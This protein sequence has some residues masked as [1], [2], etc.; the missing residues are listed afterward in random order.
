MT[1]LTTIAGTLIILSACQTSHRSSV[2]EVDEEKLIPNDNPCK[3][4][5][6]QYTMGMANMGLPITREDLSL[7][8][9]LGIAKV[10]LEGWDRMKMDICESTDGV[11]RVERIFK[12]VPSAGGW[13]TTGIILKPSSNDVQAGVEKAVFAQDLSEL[14]ATFYNETDPKKSYLFKGNITKN[15]REK[16]QNGVPPNEEPKTYCEQFLSLSPYDA[17]VP[18]PQPTTVSPRMDGT[19][20][21]P[22]TVYV[23]QLIEFDPF[24]PQWKERRKLIEGSGIKLKLSYKFAG[25]P[26]MYLTYKFSKIEL[27]DTNVNP[28][29][30]NVV[31]GD[32]LENVAH[33]LSSHHGLNDAF[34]FV[35]PHGTYEF[36]RGTG[37]SAVLE[38]NY[39]DSGITD[40]SAGTPCPTNQLTECGV[41]FTE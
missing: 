35:F 20:T 5:E 13:I 27:S 17:G 11:L 14:S 23:G 36:R 39:E 28:P 4:N 7:D 32:D 37:G 2:K 22:G 8:G 21:R 1:F 38:A 25:K 6:S 16:C 19:E 3:P 31:A 10:S 40:K 29:Y 26:G 18:S 15:G 41:D 33:I 9:D 30:N 24:I 12:Q 34:K